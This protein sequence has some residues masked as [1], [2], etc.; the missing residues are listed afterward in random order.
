MC[1]YFIFPFNTMNECFHH[2]TWFSQAFQLLFM[3]QCNEHVKM[4]KFCV[5]LHAP[6]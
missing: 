6:G 4:N 1:T 3:F 5:V 2:K